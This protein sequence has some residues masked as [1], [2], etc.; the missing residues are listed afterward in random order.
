M[1]PGFLF[2]TAGGCISGWPFISS[3][4]WADH[5]SDAFGGAG[6]MWTGFGKKSE[7]NSLLWKL[8]LYFMKSEIGQFYPNKTL[9]PEEMTVA[10]MHRELAKLVRPDLTGSGQ[11]DLAVELNEAKTAADKG[12]R[13]KLESLYRKLTAG[14]GSAVDVYA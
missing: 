4:Q 2:I 10:K 1:I 7:N 9:S 12:D 6:S 11:Q 13:T 5:S 8:K 3:E 14:K